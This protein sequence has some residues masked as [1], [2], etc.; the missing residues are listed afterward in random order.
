MSELDKILEKD[1]A[2]AQAASRSNTMRSREQFNALPLIV[3]AGL[4]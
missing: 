1:Q 2:V 3:L 4:K